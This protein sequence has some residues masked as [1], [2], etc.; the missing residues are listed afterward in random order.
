M[1]FLRTVAGLLILY[2]LAATANDLLIDGNT[3]G[4][5]G[6]MLPFLTTAPRADIHG[7]MCVIGRVH[8]VGGCTAVDKGFQHMADRHRLGRQLGRRQRVPA[9]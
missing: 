7:K 2:L 4:M 5:R 3:A 1:I 6:C 8:V 9:L